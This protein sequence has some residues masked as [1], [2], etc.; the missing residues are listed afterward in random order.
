MAGSKALVKSKKTRTT[1]VLHSI[2]SS[3]CVCVLSYVSVCVC[4]FV[5]FHVCVFA[6]V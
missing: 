4:V 2:E 5:S 3:V 1:E 6:Y